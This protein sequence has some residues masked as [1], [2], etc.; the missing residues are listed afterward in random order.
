ML[1]AIVVGFV[2]IATDMKFGWM[3]L[4]LGGISSILLIALLVGVITGKFKDGILAMLGTLIVSVIGITLLMPVLYPEWSAVFAPS[5]ILIDVLRVP[6]VIV[7][8]SVTLGTVGVP[9][10]L[11]GEYF[12]GEIGM[13]TVILTPF[14][15]GLSLFL[16]GLGGYIMTRV[17]SKPPSQ[18]P[19]PTTPEP[20]AQ[21]QDQ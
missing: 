18:E 13:G 17:S 19:A 12:P 8:Q 9:W 1:W 4:F 14:I 7:Q 20:A 3:S 2:M 6:F 16:G 11:V 15:F 21:P 10:Y 5:F